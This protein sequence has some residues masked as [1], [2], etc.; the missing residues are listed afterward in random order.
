MSDGAAE[1]GAGTRGQQKGRDEQ[2]PAHIID[3]DLSGVT[4]LQIVRGA[5]YFS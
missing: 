2:C 5:V 3:C 4:Q 1:T